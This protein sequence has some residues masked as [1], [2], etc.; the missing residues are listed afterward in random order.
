MSNRRYTVLSNNGNPHPDHRHPPEFI[1]HREGCAD[2]DRGHNRTL[3][4]WPMKGPN[5]QEAIEREGLDPGIP[6][7][8]EDLGFDARDFHVCG[9]AK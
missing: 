9:C 1:V 3:E 8:L 7:G 5:V 4:R 6:G 2:L